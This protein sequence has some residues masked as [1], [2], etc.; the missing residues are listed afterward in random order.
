M[1]CSTALMVDYERDIGPGPGPS[2][3][4]MDIMPSEDDSNGTMAGRLSDEPF[5]MENRGQ[6]D[7][8]SI[9]FYST[10][11]SGG[12]AFLDSEVRL[13]LKETRP[14]GPLDEPMASPTSRGCMVGLTFIGSN[15]VSPMGTVSANGTS[16]FFATRDSSRWVSDVA[17][18]REIVYT[19]LYDRIDLVY[20][21][22]PTGWKSEFI[23]HP[24]GD[25]RAIEVMVRGHS[26]IRVDGGSSLV[27]STPCGDIVDDGLLAYSVGQSDAMVPCRFEVREGGCYGFIVGA[28][29][30][31]KPLVIDPL[32][33]FT[34]IG[35]DM[36]DEIRDTAVDG[37]GNHYLTGV[38]KSSDFPTTPGVYKVA[39]T[40]D[41]FETYILKLSPDGKR[42]I[43]STFIF[44]GDSAGIAID[45]IGNVYLTGLTS[46]VSFPTTSGAFQTSL[47][48]GNDAYVLK[49][50]VDGDELD[51]ST[52]LGGA[53]IDKG[54]DLVLGA[55][56]SAIVTGETSSDNFP[57][58]PGSFRPG[59]GC[60]FIAKLSPGGDSL[61]YSGRLGTLG[62]F[63]SEGPQD[64]AKD[65]NG[66]IYVSGFTSAPGFL[67]T[68]GAFQPTLHGWE[69]L[70]VAKV[71]Q[72]GTQLIYSSFLGGSERE[73]LSSIAVDDVGCAYVTGFSFS[74]DF[75]T[76]IGAVQPIRE[77][78]TVFVSK[79][80]PDGTRLV[81]STF[82]WSGSGAGFGFGMAIDSNQDVLITG[83]ASNRSG[84]TISPG[85]MR[86]PMVNASAFLLKLSGDGSTILYANRFGDCEGNHLL[87]DDEGM[88]YIAGTVRRATLE[89]GTPGAYQ[90]TQGGYVDG[91][92]CKFPAD[93]TPP[94]VEAGPDVVLDQHATM[95]FDG[96]DSSDDIGVADWNWTFR[97]N[98]T[99]TSLGGVSPSFKFDRAGRYCVTL[100]VQDAAG[101]WAEDTLNVTVR[102]QT[103]PVALAGYDVRVGLNRS[104]WFDGS[105]SSDDVG[106]VNFTWAMTDGLIDLVFPGPTF[107]YRFGSLGTYD[108]TLRVED[109]SGNWA[110]DALKVWV[111]DI[112]PPLADAGEDQDVVQHQ[113]VELDGTGSCDDVGIVTWVWS[114]HYNGS[115]VELESESCSYTFHLAGLYTVT[116]Y[117]EDAAGNWAKDNVTIEV[118][119]STPPVAVAG[120]DLTVD[121]LDEVLLDGS[122]SYDD[123]GVVNW[124]WRIVGEGLAADL[125][126]AMVRHAFERPG[127][128]EATLRVVDAGDNW[129]TDSLM[130]TVRAVQ[131]P[132]ADAGNDVTVEQHQTVSF[133]G[134][135]S[136]D[137]RGIASWTW[138]FTYAGGTVRL[139]GPSPEHVFDLAG[140]YAVTLVVVNTLGESGS[141]SMNVTVRDTERPHAVVSGSEEARV[142]IPYTFDGSTSVDNVG[143]VS[144]AWVIE[145]G[146]GSFGLEGKMANFTFQRAGIYNVTLVVTDAAGQEDS[147]AYTLTVKEPS[148]AGG[149]NWLGM[150]IAVVVVVLALACAGIYLLRRQRGA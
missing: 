1:G 90:P 44:T 73:R 33:Y 46:N 79:I 3:L 10:G 31:S 100:T 78:G 48:G 122:A 34:Y 132:Y 150:L 110:M 69:E 88:I 58:T 84:F 95:T 140:V 38:T 119:D 128:Y 4:S 45:G 35:T 2:T 63:G 72:N 7:D 139:G 92:A 147:Q 103:P 85:A 93:M 115:L 15:P 121:Q 64:I 116:L 13:T 76:T 138:T 141:A 124:T 54:V 148:Q 50:S 102:D 70:F 57:V 96:S 41:E 23:V 77:N 28:Y 83:T 24:G 56:G 14:T 21:A 109:A 37:E 29:D 98:G 125:S 126:G 40:G 17:H 47:A 114:F 80:S 11:G 26:S 142:G 67:T 106:I 123:I 133:D 42:L 91:F 53:E 145:S 51:Y 117:V 22:E 112:D 60:V 39:K 129:A 108:V 62:G 9:R 137:P 105:N 111:V 68:S 89:I 20:R 16:S 61:I 74:D 146:N 81:F 27:V 130:V 86:L 75:P 55:D 71:N 49:L 149:H 52:L 144:W 136:R 131:F 32:L 59:Y 18:L 66:N 94:I 82:L 118:R 12:I 36:W 113:P 120:P 99:N 143:I 107:S 134:S 6:L 87:L 135:R 65:G 19:G 127:T 101:N 30:E 5:F 104:L 25:P 43:F 8:G 97:Y